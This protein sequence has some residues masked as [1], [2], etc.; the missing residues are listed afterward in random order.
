MPTLFTIQVD[1]PN[2]ALRVEYESFTECLSDSGLQRWFN[3]G[4]VTA[5]R[6][7]QG[8]KRIAAL[9]QSLITWERF[10]DQLISN[11]T[12]ILRGMF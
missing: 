1:T 6:I 8:P 9:P 7:S 11:S 4:E 3:E 2:D 12:V 5:Y 10:K